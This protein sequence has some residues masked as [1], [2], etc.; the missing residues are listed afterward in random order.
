MVIDPRHGEQHGYSKED[1]MVYVIVR[2]A[3]LSYHH[4]VEGYKS[5]EG[6]SSNWKVFK[7]F[8]VTPKHLSIMAYG[9]TGS[10]DGCRLFRPLFSLV[11]PHHRIN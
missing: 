9:K 7:S 2:Q 1:K 6:E 8:V 10:M 3:I 5:D 4:E 11:V